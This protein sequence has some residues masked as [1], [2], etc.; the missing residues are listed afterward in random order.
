MHIKKYV[1]ISM[2]FLLCSC[3]CALDDEDRDKGK[4]NVIA[5]IAALMIKNKACETNKTD[6][7]QCQH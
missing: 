2:L 7:T 5:C 3:A 1:S 6:T 4:P